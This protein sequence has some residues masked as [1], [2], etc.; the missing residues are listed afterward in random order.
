MGTQYN[1]LQAA[2]HSA[3][4]FANVLPSFI[5]IPNSPSVPSVP[6]ATIT[7]TESDTPSRVINSTTED[8]K[9]VWILSL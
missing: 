8:I 1:T 3:V 9:E 6:S 2:Q 5:A 7:P 4:L